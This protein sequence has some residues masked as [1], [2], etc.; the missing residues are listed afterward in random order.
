M[1]LVNETTWRR[2]HRI[3]DA[4]RKHLGYT[5]AGLA[6][7][8]G[9]SPAWFYKLKDETGDP[10]VRHRKFLEQLDAA[11]RWRA[12]TSM[13]LLVDDRADWDDALLQD[14]EDSLIHATDRIATFAFMVEQ[15]LRVLDP[16]DADRMMR[17]LARTL[18]LPVVGD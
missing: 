18:G 15:R 1:C 13:S 5:V 16:D 4:R 12:G 8:G 10:S 6:A 11:L 2:L 3:A 9:P 17:D 14:E 7:A